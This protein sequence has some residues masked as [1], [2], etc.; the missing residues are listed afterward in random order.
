M[1]V[2]LRVQQMKNSKG[3]ISVE[4][5]MITPIFLLACFLMI[6]L[7]ASIKEQEI[8][9]YAMNHAAF[10]IAIAGLSD[11]FQN[12]VLATTMIQKHL[13]DKKTRIGFNLS[14]VNVQSDG[15]FQ[16]KMLWH[17]NYPLIGN[18]V[19]QLN[20][21]SRLLTLGDGCFKNQTSLVYITSFGEKYHL[22]DCIHLSKS[23][24]PISIKEAEEGGYE[25]CWH[26][27]KGLPSFEKAPS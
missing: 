8:V 3:S 22:Q 13:N 21:T 14:A 18:K 17:S 9:G 20:V 24:I 11:D 19:H 6:F 15:S 7:L 27:V 2:I 4:A 5:A 12:S 25:P 10:D 26:C 23:K 16:L 1:V